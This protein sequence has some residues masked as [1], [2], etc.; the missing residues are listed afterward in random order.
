MKRSAFIDLKA[1]RETNKISQAE[2]AEF[3]GVNRSF[4]SQIESGLSK[5]PDDALKKIDA[6][7]QVG[8]KWHFT[9]LVPFYDRILALQDYFDGKIDGGFI[10]S[11]IEKGWFSFDELREIGNGHTGL[12][13]EVMI[14]IIKEYPEINY[15]WL[16]KGEEPM[17]HLN[18][19][20]PY[21]IKQLIT[22]ID[23]LQD[24]IDLLLARTKTIIDLL[25]SERK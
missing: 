13:S 6:E 22:K 9:G 12:P 7:C 5:L 18:T 10:S 25:M 15:E 17:I 14:K 4:I 20:N 24:E 16:A 19:A 21:T 1:F 2:L 8:N 23:M 3:L 11:S